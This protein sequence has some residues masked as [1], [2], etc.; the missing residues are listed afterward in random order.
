MNNLVPSAPPPADEAGT[1]V[2]K[3]LTTRGLLFRKEFREV[4]V[5]RCEYGAKL[6]ISTVIISTMQTSTSPSRVTYG[7]RFE[8]EDGDRELGTAFLDFDECPEVISA[9]EFINRLAREM[10][11]QQLDTTEINYLTKDDIKFGFF[12][13]QDRGHLAFLNLNSY[14][15]AV[16][17]SLPMLEFIKKNLEFARDFLINKGAVL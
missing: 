3:F 9:H 8:V 17:L 6:K 7:V 4:N 2:K 1:D 5:M 13:T 11:T 15:D 16:F 12:Q 14:G 10:Q